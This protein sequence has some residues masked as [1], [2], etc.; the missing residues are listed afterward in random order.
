[1]LF[2]KKKNSKFGRYPSCDLLNNAI[3]FMFEG[4]YDTALKEVILA[5]R[6]ADGYYYEDLK[7]K[8]K[9]FIGWTWED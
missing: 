4:K 3:R 8:I 9:E 2:T 6:K 7:P 1:M 5:I